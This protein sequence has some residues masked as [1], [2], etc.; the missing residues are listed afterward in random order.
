MSLKAEYKPFDKFLAQGRSFIESPGVIT[1]M[2][3]D[4][5]IVAYKRY[6]ISQLHDEPLSFK[7]NDLDKAVRSQDME[8]CH[9][10]L[11]R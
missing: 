4:D 5:A 10:S 11:K 1:G 6:V 2:A 8:L 9:D 3:F 7:L